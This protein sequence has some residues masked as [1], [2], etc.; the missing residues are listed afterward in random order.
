MRLINRSPKVSLWLYFVI[1]AST[2]CAGGVM[3]EESENAN[4]ESPDSR[5]DIVERV[6]FSGDWHPEFDQWDGID[7]FLLLQEA[8]WVIRKLWGKY[9]FHE[10]MVQ[11]EQ[12]LAVELAGAIPSFAKRLFISESNYIFDDQVRDEFTPL[13]RSARSRHYWADAETLV[14]VHEC[15]RSDGMKYRVVAKRFMS[16]ERD[17]QFVEMVAE[18]ENSTTKTARQVY[19]RIKKN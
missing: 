13:G 6:D 12:A 15:E 18:L 16:S 17:K 1:L 10:I 8:P 2:L 7:E 11:D 14:S 4:T 19:T 5:E 9:P 3:S